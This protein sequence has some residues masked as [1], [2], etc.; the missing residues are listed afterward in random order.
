MTPRRLQWA[1]MAVVATAMGAFTLTA[2]TRAADHAHG[3]GLAIVVDRAGSDGAP[4]HAT[5]TGASGKSL[6]I[7]LQDGFA[8]TK[9]ALNQGDLSPAGPSAYVF[10]DARLKDRAG[11]PIL[12]VFGVAEASD[13]GAMRV[14]GETANGDPRL[15][16]VEDTFALTGVER[17]GGE[18]RLIGLRSLSQLAGRCVSSY[19]PFSIFT[20]G[21]DGRFHYSLALSKAYNLNHYIW[22]GPKSTEAI[23]V[24]GR[25]ATPRLASKEDV[26]RASV[27]TSSDDN[28]HF[29]M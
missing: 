1:A 9:D 20:L 16:L 3:R 29:R 19:D 8:T 21:A 10:S 7:D 27:D 6:R 14:V 11:H 15:L 26:K 28:C 23:S 4:H 17:V 5:A 2:P 12:I 22:A 13:P 25:G 24:D 18:S